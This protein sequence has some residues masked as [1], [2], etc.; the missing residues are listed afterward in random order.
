MLDDCYNASPVSAHAALDTLV[1]LAGVSRSVAVLGSML[2]LGVESPRF[3]R[4][5]GAHAAARGV[6]LLIVVGSGELPEAIHEG[7][8]AAGL[9][10]E[11]ALRAESPEAGGRLAA[12]RAGSGAWI[13]VKASR[14]ARLEGVLA[15]L[16]RRAASRGPSPADEGRRG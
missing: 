8:V 11:R 13:L 14:G 15:E 10:A 1:E 5:L 2:E 12:E 7:A 16:E 6:S 9:P 4:E 3:H